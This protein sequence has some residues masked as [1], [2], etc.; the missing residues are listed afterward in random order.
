M[1]YFMIWVLVTYMRYVQFV[2]IYNTMCVVF[3]HTYNIEGIQ[4][5]SCQ[6]MSLYHKDN[7]EQKETK[8]SRHRMNPLLSSYLPE[9]NMNFSYEDIS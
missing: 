8:K 5:M 7:F 1:F 3:L 6:N 2:N 4:S 9:Q